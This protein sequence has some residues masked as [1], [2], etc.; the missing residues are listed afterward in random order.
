MPEH[1]TGGATREARASVCVFRVR[2]SPR[3]GHR[4]ASSLEWPATSWLV[5][6]CLVFS[7]VFTSGVRD[8]D[9]QDMGFLRLSTSS[10]DFVAT[11]GGVQC[12]GV[13]V[14]RE[15]LTLRDCRLDVDG[16]TSTLTRSL[17]ADAFSVDAAC[18]R[19]RYE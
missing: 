9:P 3:P 10:R 2:T 12:T 17:P 4:A 13:P 16:S 11:M 6:G 15:I 1:R 14:R 8:G 19:R 7:L 18:C 5:Y